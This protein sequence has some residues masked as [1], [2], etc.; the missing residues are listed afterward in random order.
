MKKVTCQEINRDVV[1]QNQLR[2]SKKAMN[3][4]SER[5]EKEEKKL[6][7]QVNKL[8]VENYHKLYHRKK[9]QYL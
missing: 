2:M 6:R 5:D 1:L 8:L 3:F 7:D 4:T 9:D